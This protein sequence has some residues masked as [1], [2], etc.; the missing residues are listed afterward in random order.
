MCMDGGSIGGG[1]GTGVELCEAADDGSV[2]RGGGGRC[3]QAGAGAGRRAG[4][5]GR[6]RGKARARLGTF[7]RC[8]GTGDVLIDSL[9][10][11][12]C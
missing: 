3:E 2:A 5:C 1:E 4:G 10:D 7:R 12:L 6:R 11:L 8:T 9:L